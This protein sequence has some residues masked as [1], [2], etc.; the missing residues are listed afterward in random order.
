MVKKRVA[1]IGSNG[2]LGSELVRFLSAENE[3]IP[4]THQEI[5]IEN[6]NSCLKISDLKPDV[7][8]N[9]AAFHDVKICEKNLKQSYLT[10]SL[11]SQNIAI[12]ADH[13]QAYLIHISTDYVFDGNK[14]TPYLESDEIRPL[15]VYGTTKALGEMLSTQYNENTC[16]LRIAALYGKDVCRGKPRLNFVDLMLQ[17]VKSGKQISV[18]ENEYT[19]PTSA[20]SIAN[21]IS[22]L[23]SNPHTGIFHSTCEGQCSWYEFANEIFKIK[24]INAN[25]TPKTVEPDFS[26]NRPQYSVLE[27]RE[28]KNIGMNT[29]PHWKESL[30]IYLRSNET[31]S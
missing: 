12:T 10:N 11:G 27:N 29:F 18:V 3:I 28:F 23:I 7:I 19:T 31:S 30:E 24:N 26:L 1:I 4:L 15:N 22:C 2:Q 14:N 20:L 5:Q 6:L 17:L 21:Q 16:I 13:S 9:T 25:I 8:I